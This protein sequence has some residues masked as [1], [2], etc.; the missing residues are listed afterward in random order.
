MHILLSENDRTAK[1]P[2]SAHRVGNYIKLLKVDHKM[3]WES[4]FIQPE[5]TKL[6]IL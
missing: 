5:M 3:S 1:Q 2:V 6:F 4:G